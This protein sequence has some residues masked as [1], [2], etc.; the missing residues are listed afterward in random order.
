M[1]TGAGRQARIVELI[2]DEAVHSQ[3]ELLGLLDA[4]GIETT[5]ATLSRDLDELGAIKVPRRAT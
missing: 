5:Q 4:E 1:T 3:T 2:R